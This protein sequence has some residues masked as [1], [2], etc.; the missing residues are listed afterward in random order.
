MALA[1]QKED[2]EKE[3]CCRTEISGLSWRDF[4][5]EY[6]VNG[7]TPAEFWVRTTEPLKPLDMVCALVRE[8][9]WWQ[10]RVRIRFTS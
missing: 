7:L 10:N 9:E 3:Q 6:A 8:R 4:A 5:G 1:V 2:A